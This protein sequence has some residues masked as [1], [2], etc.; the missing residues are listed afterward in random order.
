M[1]L[2][3]ELLCQAFGLLL[4]ENELLE[5]QGHDFGGA[6]PPEVG[7]LENAVCQV[8]SVSPSPCPKKLITAAVQREKSDKDSASTLPIGIA[9]SRMT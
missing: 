2:G 7:D 4:V 3:L 6:N 8:V 9:A 5:R 1:L